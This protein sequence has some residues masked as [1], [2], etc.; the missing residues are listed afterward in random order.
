VRHRYE[1][2]NSTSLEAS[3]EIRSEVRNLRAAGIASLLAA[4]VFTVAFNN[5]MRYRRADSVGK[6]WLHL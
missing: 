3:L 5:W 1:Q 2:P 4:L 6:L